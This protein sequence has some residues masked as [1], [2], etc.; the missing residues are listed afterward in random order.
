[1][2][3]RNELKFILYIIFEGKGSF[4]SGCRTASKVEAFPRREMRKKLAVERK[5]DKLMSAAHSLSGKSR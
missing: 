4:M 3:E 2:I 5:T 1:M